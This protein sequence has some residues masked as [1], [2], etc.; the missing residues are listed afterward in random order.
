MNKFNLQESEKNR[1][2]LMHRVIKEQFAGRIDP[3]S[4]ESPAT[5]VTPATPATPTTP[6]T[7]TSPDVPKSI[8]DQ[9]EVFITNGCVKNGNVVKMT[10]TNPQKEF[11]IKQESTKTP[12]K[13]RYFF[14]DNTV[15]MNDETGKFQILPNKWACNTKAVEAAKTNIDRTT[16]EGGWKLRKDITDTDENVENPQ[17]YEKKVISGIV[18][19]RSLSGAGIQAAL[20]ERGQQIF[21]KYKRNGGLTE[22][23]VDPEQAQTWV[24]V[25]IGSKPDF[26]AD[27]YMYF[28]PEITIRDPNIAAAIQASVE[29]TIPKDKKDCKRN[30][31][32]YHDNYIRKRMMEP[33]QLS[34]QKYKV[35]ACKNEFYQNWGFLGSRKIDKLLDIMSGGIG[36]PSRRGDDAKWR[37]N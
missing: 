24:K 21:D 29:E 12:G 16:Q 37:L 1:I 28:N 32:D 26:S 2:L 11:A 25:K 20:T 10:S 34:A 18:H 17:M 4:L 13:F 5:P 36:G 22:Q 8:K 14:I 7:S 3:E 30:I 6:A 15:G 35:Q 31:E 33:N 23:E 27:F 9:L 19:Y